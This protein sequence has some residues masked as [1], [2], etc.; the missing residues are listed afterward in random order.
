M[1]QLAAILSVFALQA[2]HPTG[3]DNNASISGSLPSLATVAS[4]QKPLRIVSLDFCSDQ[5]VLKLVDRDRILA[6][7]PDA[8]K[9][10]SYMRET[11]KGLPTVRPTA[12]DVLIL[13]P[14]LIVRSYGGGPNAESFFESAGIAVITLGWASD[15]EGIMSVMRETSRKL[16]ESARGEAVIK[17]MQTRIDALPHPST[18]PEALYMTPTG[19]T[20]GEG[21]L[22]HEMMI[23]AGL[24]NFQKKAGWRSLPLERLVYE[25]PDMIAA[26]FYDS[27]VND[28]DAWGAANHPIA[29]GQM[30]NLP[31]VNLQGAWTSCGG[32][33][34]MDAIE[35]LAS[36]PIAG[37]TEPRRDR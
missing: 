24:T 28:I 30:K 15:I 18:R 3:A 12:E 17:D 31:T 35:A 33:F 25:K 4:T 13:E 14:D 11:A 26:A 2:C 16:G 21:S 20:T 7:S 29:R 8:V 5:F 10:F 34:L 22:I 23:T 37:Q 6:V 9:D 1:K 32:W 27:Q 19:V 36:A